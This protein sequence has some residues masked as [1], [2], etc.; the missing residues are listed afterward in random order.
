M[1]TT[2]PTPS[3]TCTDG[4]VRQ[5]HAAIVDFLAAID[6]GHAS[7]ALGLFTPDASFAARGEQLQGREQIAAFLAGREAEDR[8]T[9]HLIGNE[10]VR[11]CTDDE[12]EITALLFL[13]ELQP[14]GQYRL[15]RVLDTTQLFRRAHDRW[16]IHRRT[17]TPLH[18]AAA[19]S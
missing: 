3:G 15:Q 2:P 5:C 4:S 7:Q 12:V 17:T 8:H 18:P 13:H 19:R 6:R 10:V 9:A 1:T 11:R 16:L 14:D